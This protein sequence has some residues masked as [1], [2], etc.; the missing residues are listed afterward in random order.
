MLQLLHSERW[1]VLRSR[2]AAP[3]C[4]QPEE[5]PHTPRRKPSESK[6]KRAA[7]HC[8]HSPPRSVSLLLRLLLL[9]PAIIGASLA[10]I[11]PSVARSS[12]GS[13]TTIWT[14]QIPFQ[15]S[16]VFDLS[17]T[18]VSP[19]QIAVKRFS[20][21]LL[22]FFC[23]FTWKVSCVVFRAASQHS[24]HSHSWLSDSL[25]SKITLEKDPQGCNCVAHRQ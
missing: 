18:V 2:P 7:S 4:T 19:M 15:L 21:F 12:S 10:F 16:N 13:R 20:I 23:Y 3:L 1:A 17:E 24:Q 6:S 22:F 25:P 11:S 8:A 9:A 5:P 14:N